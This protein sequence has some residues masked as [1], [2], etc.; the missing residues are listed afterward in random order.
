MTRRW[1]RNDDPAAAVRRIL[2]AADEAFA[3]LGVAR[4][5]MGEVARFAGCS[6]GTLYRY[7][8]TRDALHRAYVR[9]KAGE[10]HRRAAD[11][12]ASMADPQERLV[13]YVLACVRAVREDP[14][15]SAW[16]V[17]DVSGLAARYSRSID[18]IGSL[19]AGLAPELS[20]ARTGEEERFLR[21]RWLVRV[22]VSLLA[23]PEPSGSDERA[24]VERFAV[25]AVLDSPS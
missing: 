21:L 23:D 24:L 16:F 15:T 6:R 2:E 17:T 9:H 3:E 12:A 20:R 5:G 1:G 11:A 22:I 18:V 8:P 4:A 10:I 7:F 14:A 25:P 13:E 19:T